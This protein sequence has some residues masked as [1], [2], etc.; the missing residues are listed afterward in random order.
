MERVEHQKSVTWFCRM[1]VERAGKWT[2]L[3]F[4]LLEIPREFSDAEVFRGWA[5]LNVY[6]PDKAVTKVS[7]RQHVPM[8][9]LPETIAGEVDGES[10]VMKLSKVRRCEE[11]D[12][13]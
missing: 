5:F 12:V 7:V 2:D 4:V 13:Y 11:W 1:T 8:L 9:G 3:G 6:R 10:V